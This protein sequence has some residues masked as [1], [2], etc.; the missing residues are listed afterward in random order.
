MLYYEGELLVAIDVPYVSTTFAI[1]KPMWVKCSVKLRKEGLEIKLPNEI[2]TIPHTTI[3]L[4]N[5]A[6][7]HSV[8]NV[9]QFTSKYSAFIAIDYRKNATIGYE[10]ILFSTLLAG[11]QTEIYKLRY[12]LMTILGLQT[13][14]LLRDLN[15]EEAR[16]LSLL[17]DN[18][19]NVEQLAAIFDENKDLLYRTFYVLVS[20]SFVD[21]RANLTPAGISILNKIKG[22][23]E[24]KKSD[25]TKLNEKI[26]EIVKLW[27]DSEKSIIMDNKN[28]VYLKYGESTLSGSI[29]TEDMWRCL[30]LKEIKETK[31]EDL[32][33]SGLGL[34]MFTI[35]DSTIFLR[36]Y[37]DSVIFTL[38]GLLDKKE[39]IQMRILYCLY[40]GIVEESS[41]LSILDIKAHTFLEQYQLMENMEIINNMT[42]SN[43]GLELIHK[44][45]KGYCT[46]LLIYK[47][48]STR[49][50]EQMRMVNTKKVVMDKLKQKHEKSKTAHF[51]TY[52]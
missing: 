52:Y 31:I 27:D 37:D 20:K 51:A 8:I 9:I 11:N 19:R 18:I 21:E 29:L 13:D 38:K 44:M 30:P 41:I 50:L 35:N 47:D 32:K 5:R 15:I 42:I 48:V 4:V 12:F 23:N 36:T 22:I 25:E 43:K 26:D 28:K 17:D 39:D 2:F 24:V 10:N 33:E 45:I 7:P 14:P 1:E 40:L 6:L 16:L 3:E 46:V 49:R 34:V